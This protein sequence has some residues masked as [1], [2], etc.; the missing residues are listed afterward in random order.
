MKYFL[1][2]IVLLQPFAAGWVLRFRRSWVLAVAAVVTGI[3]FG[4]NAWADTI[5]AYVAGVIVWTLGEIAHS[6]VSSAVVA[7]LSPVHAR[8]RY[9]GLFSMS[10]GMAFF[11]G[12]VLGSWA[13]QH[14]GAS[15]LWLSCIALGGLI[16]C[17]HVLVAAARRKRMDEL[18]AAGLLASV[19]IG[20]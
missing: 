9:Q 5:P 3:G 8:G 2:I 14:F 13:M 16:A 1:N 17:G 20:E 18:K 12:P 6:P 19:G 11:V 4:M 15:T 10:W 7:D